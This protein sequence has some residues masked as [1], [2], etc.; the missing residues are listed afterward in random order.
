MPASYRERWLQWPVTRKY[1]PLSTRLVKAELAGFY[2][3]DSTAVRIHMSGENAISFS[4]VGLAALPLLAE[5]TDR[6]RELLAKEIELRSSQMEFTRF[7]EGELSVKDLVRDVDAET[8]LEQL[9][10]FAV[11]SPEENARIW[12]FTQ[13]LPNFAEETVQVIKDLKGLRLI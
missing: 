6:V 5:T 12:T 9:Q 8:D 2:M 10:N 3:F 7:F 11:L 1:E 13:R 4:P